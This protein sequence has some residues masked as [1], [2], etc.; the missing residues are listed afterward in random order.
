MHL[1][2]ETKA[3][4]PVHLSAY[5]FFVYRWSSWRP[6][7][8]LPV[9]EPAEPLSVAWKISD[10]NGR[11]AYGSEYHPMIGLVRFPEQDLTETFQFTLHYHGKLTLLEDDTP[12][13]GKPERSLA[14]F[15]QSTVHEN[16]HFS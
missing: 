7:Y 3:V 13:N 2:F 12:D 11:K 6:L 10:R 15:K 8:C 1:R 16:R 5:G 14:T 9:L 4:A